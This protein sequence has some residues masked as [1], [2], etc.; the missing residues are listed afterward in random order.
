MGD[1]R[2]LGSNVVTFGDGRSQSRDSWG[3]SIQIVDPPIPLTDL[4]IALQ[5]AP[6]KVWKSQ[7]SLRKVVGFIAEKISGVPLHV[8]QRVSDTDRVRDHEAEKFFA[9]PRPFVTG[10]KLIF[11]MV[12]DWMLWDRWLVVLDEEGLRRIP[13]G[14]ISVKTDFL[15]GVTAIR[16]QTEQGLVDVTDAV[17]AYDEGWSNQSAGGISPLKT[18]SDLLEEQRRATAW[19]GAQ[20]KEAAKITGTLNTE[21]QLND[22]TKARLTESWRQYRDSKAGGTPI[23]DNGLAFTPMDRKPVATNDLEGRRLTDAEVASFYHIPPE[24]VGAR[25]GTFANIKAFRQMLYGPT[26]GPRFS[27]LEAAFNARITP[28]L[29]GENAYAEFAREAAMAGSFEEQ[30]AIYQKAVGGPYMLRSEAR[31]RQ[32]LPY[33]PGT[34]ELITPKN[35]TEGGLA[36]PSDTAPDTTGDD[37]E[38]TWWEKEKR[39][40]HDH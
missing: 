14:L 24:L 5:N 37:A 15:G 27:R 18:L 25:D 39:G 13:A 38:K 35:V 23:L 36:D 40:E 20:W 30:A 3:D 16:V 22:R 21:Q 26:L 34:D 29:A 31:A 8:Y 9:T 1:A 19:R 2:W 12:V 32:N 10:P 4:G 33:I 6:D 7:P 28:F 11:D 17:V